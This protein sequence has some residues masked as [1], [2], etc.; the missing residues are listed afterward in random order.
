MNLD[1]F[2]VQAQAQVLECITLTARIGRDKE[3]GTTR[4]RVRYSFSAASIF[5]EEQFFMKEKRTHSYTAKRDSSSI[6]EEVT[7]YKAYYYIYG[8]FI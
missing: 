3:K 7:E 8:L 5:I 6:L 4:I 2:V 1:R